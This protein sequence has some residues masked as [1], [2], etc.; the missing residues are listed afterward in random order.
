[1][2]LRSIALTF[3]TFH[4]VL[5]SLLSFTFFNR[6]NRYYNSEEYF[7]EI[8]IALPR[9]K[10][11]EQKRY[12]AQALTHALL[13]VFGYNHEGI[14]SQFLKAEKKMELLEEKTLRALGL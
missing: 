8:F 5:I 12:Y 14:G 2:P 7:G 3:I 4:K 6:N 10:K 1:M 9:S 11:R 13:H